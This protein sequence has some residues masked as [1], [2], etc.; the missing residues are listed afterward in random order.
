MIFCET[1]HFDV[2]QKQ[3]ISTAQCTTYLPLD[4]GQVVIS[5]TDIG[6]IA[7]TNCSAG[8]ILNGNISIRTCDSTGKWSF[9]RPYCK[10]I[11]KLYHM[12]S[13]LLMHSKSFRAITGAIL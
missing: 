5:G 7:T 11:Y 1:H 6:S 12:E 13:E 2:Q 8:Y 4:N 10:G 9:P 3:C